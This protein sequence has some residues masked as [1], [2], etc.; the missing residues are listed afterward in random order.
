[1]RKLG[2]PDHATVDAGG[3]WGPSPVG[4]LSPL[5]PVLP[6]QQTIAVATG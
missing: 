6:H 2:R 5:R 3:L 1:M 4:P